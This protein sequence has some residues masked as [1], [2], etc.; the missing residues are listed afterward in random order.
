MTGPAKSAE[1]GP[2]LAAKVES[3]ALRHVALREEVQ[4]AQ[5]AEALTR[6]RLSQ[7][8][9]DALLALARAEADGRA[10]AAKAYRAAALPGVRH[11]RRNR[12]KRRLD[13]A[14][15]RLGPVG[16]VL[17]IACSGLWAK[18][19]GFASM[20]AYARRAADRAAQPAALLDQAWYL[21]TYPDVAAGRLAPLVHYISLGWMEGRAPHPLFDRDFYVARNAEELAA[22]GLSPLEHFVHIG[23]AKGCDPHPL[24]SIDHYVAQAPELGQTGENPLAHYLRDGWRRDLSPHPLFQAARYRGQL[25]EA[26]SQ[27]PA[28]VHYVTAGSARGLKPHRLFDP[29]WYRDQY[30]DVAAG[31]FEALSHYVMAGGHEGRNPGPWFDAARYMALRGDELRTDVDPL[32]DYLQGGAWTVAQPLAGE[33]AD[34]RLTPLEN[35]ASLSDEA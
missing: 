27:V 22:T 18:G 10:A 7:A 28:L 23:A 5:A 12:I 35:W 33:S 29:A 13:R 6:S 34:P 9:A 26:E 1:D 16:S 20:A 24:F 2:E 4:R 14:L 31:G 17:V 3:L 19:G 21:A 30:P 11:R 25:T 32:T 15:V 8:L